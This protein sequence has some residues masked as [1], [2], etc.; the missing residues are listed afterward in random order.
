MIVLVMW[1]RE[2]LKFRVFKGGRESVRKGR[3]C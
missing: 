3:L 2:Q 1:Q